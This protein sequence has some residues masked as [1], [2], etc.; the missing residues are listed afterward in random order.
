MNLKIFFLTFLILI[1]S[2]LQAQN[3]ETIKE[4]ETFRFSYPTKDINTLS[5]V[6]KYGNIYYSGTSNDSLIIE[7]TIKIKNPNDEDAIDIFRMININPKILKKKLE[8]KTEFSGNFSSNDEFTVSYVIK[9]P[10]KS[11]IVFN[12]QFGDITLETFSG[13][14]DITLYFGNLSAKESFSKLKLKLKNG[15]TDFSEIGVINADLSNSQFFLNK[16]SNIEINAE[17]SNINIKNA[18]L[19]NAKGQTSEFTLNEVDNISITGLQC[20]VKVS[21]IKKSGFFEIQKGNL[22]V[23]KILSTTENISVAVTETPVLLGLESEMSHTLYGEITNGSLEHPEKQ[24]L[25]LLWEGQTLSFGGEAGKVHSKDIQTAII[26]F[27]E[28]ENVTITYIK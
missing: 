7:A 1:V 13:N 5:V 25:R 14:A 19:I 26:L 2:L 9:G 12:N 28:N 27:S 21:V 16:T 4:E 17:L 11:D 22:S 24:K 20:F 8:I 18:G 3:T 6:N 23:N 10:P 15:K